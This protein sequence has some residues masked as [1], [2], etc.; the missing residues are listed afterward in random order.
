MPY[1]KRHI[2][3]AVLQALKASPVVFVNGPRQAGKSTLVQELAKKA[4]P[5]DYVTFDSATQMGAAAASPESF[6]RSYD[7]PLIIDEVQMVPDL[8]RPLKTLVDELRRKRK[9]GIGGRFLLTGSANMMALPQLADAL[10]GRM[11]IITLYP[12]SAAEVSG[13]K[14]DFAARLFSNGLKAGKITS[15]L[16]LLT[17]MA[18]ATFP[19]IT[20]ADAAVRATWFEGYITTILQRDLRQVADVEKAA[21]L[22]AL[23]RI[24]A[25]RAGSLVNEADISRSVGLNAV[26][27]KRYRTILQMMFLTFDVQPWFRNIGKRIVKSPKAYLVDT[28]LLCRLLQGTPEDIRARDPQLFGH[29]VEN[30]VATELLKQ[31]AASGMHIQLLHFRT[32]DGK[33]VDFVLERSDGR[34]AGIE[35]KAGDSVEG[36]DFS[37]LRELQSKTGKDF[38]VGVV[39]YGGR[40]IVSF[41]KSLWAIPHALLWT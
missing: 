13:A 25:S 38:S 6:L 24:V 7:G 5:A 33:E 36:N 2:T 29:L 1:I 4:W 23:L 28:S 8:F 14:G 37:G 16:D 20:R 10:V 31:Q 12:L 18:R 17:A 27:G 19:E 39:L 32:S 11:S 3:P 40:E 22:P 15:K 41:G 30:F 26:T 21:I 34:L 9:G 35:V